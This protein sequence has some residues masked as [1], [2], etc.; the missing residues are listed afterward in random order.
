[1][2]SRTTER[3]RA[4]FSQLPASVQRQVRAAYRRFRENPHH[5]GLHFK[6]VHPTQ[7]IYSVRISR[8]YRAVGIRDADEIV[9]FWIGSHAD[10]NQLLQ[11]FGRGR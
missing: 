2:I 9:W 7:P 10:Y 11:R 1:M 5:P 6:P 8:D 4:A 3:F